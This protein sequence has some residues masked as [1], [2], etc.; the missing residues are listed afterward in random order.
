M[1]LLAAAAGICFAAFAASTTLSRP[2]TGLEEVTDPEDSTNG[3]FWD[4]SG[5]PAA[6]VSDGVSAIGAAV[7]T[8][9]ASSAGA[10]D[11]ELD[12][13]AYTW[14][15]SA[16]CAIRTDPPPLILIVR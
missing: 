11:D 5:R 12:V 6:S 15:E 14:D 3:G 1:I 16:A 2:V 7:S 9:S 10:S 8:A 13:R 4:L